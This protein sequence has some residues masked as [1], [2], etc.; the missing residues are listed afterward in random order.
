MIT[1]QKPMATPRQSA[2]LNE[3]NHMLTKMLSIIT[4]HCLAHVTGVLVDIIAGCHV[5]SVVI[6]TQQYTHDI[7]IIG[8]HGT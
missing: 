4:I 6:V 3:T 1:A 2:D 5:L 7:V 8:I